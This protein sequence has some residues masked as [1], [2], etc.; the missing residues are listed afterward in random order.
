MPIANRAVLEAE[1]EP[2]GLQQAVTAL[3]SDITEQVQDGEINCSTSPNLMNSL[4][5]L[6]LHRMWVSKAFGGLNLSVK[7]GFS[8]VRTLAAADASIA[9]QIGVQGAIGRLSDYLLPPVAEAIF[10]SSRLVVGAVN[11]SGS[12]VKTT[13]GYTISG[14]WTFASGSAHADW[15]VS[16]CPL[17]HNEPGENDNKP[18]LIY[19]FVPREACNFYHDW[20][21][22]GLRGTG[23]VTYTIDDVFVPERNTVSGSDVLMPPPPRATTA[24][25][26]GYFDFG[27]FTSGATVMGIADASLSIFRSGAANRKAAASSAPRNNNH[28]VQEKFARATAAVKAAELLFLDAAGI[29]ETRGAGGTSDVSAAVRL[30]AAAATE[31]AVSAVNTVFA[32][33]GATAVHRS[34]P[35]DKCFRDIHTASK[36]ITLSPSHFE[37]VGQ[38]LLGGELLMRR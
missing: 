1:T 8:L 30:A 20:D 33:A 17:N 3:L 10:G 32:L 19:A 11:P 13:G 35:L 24:Y 37:T 2:R 28:V 12:A 21:T 31:Q 26:I 4:F 14:R 29:V 36:H 23:S 18:Q 27:P 6:Q 38:W 7:D 22:L 5:D 25:N 34:S 9:W 16:C 15:I